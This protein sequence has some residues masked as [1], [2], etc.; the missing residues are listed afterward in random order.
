MSCHVKQTSAQRRFT[1]GSVG[2]RSEMVKEGGVQDAKRKL[3]AEI[4]KEKR[5]R[6]REQQL[7][8]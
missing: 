2:R 3:E 5:K 4:K 6:E 8:L 7:W 1:I